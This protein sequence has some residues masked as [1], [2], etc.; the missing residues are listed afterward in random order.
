MSKRGF[1]IVL[2]GIDGS[3]STTQGRELAHHLR[4]KHGREVTLTHEPSG[5]PIGAIIRLA[6]QGRIV[7]TDLRNTFDESQAAGEEPR[8][9]DARTYALLFA[10]DRTDHLATEV[11]PSLARGRDVV[12]D[13]YLLSMLAYQGVSVDVEWLLEISRGALVP[14]LTIFL[15]LPVE[16]ALERMREARWTREQFETRENL[17]RVIERYER[18]L[19]MRLPQLGPV[20]RIDSS[21]PLPVVTRRVAT[22]VNRLLA[23]RG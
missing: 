7:G 14:D 8:G 15:D 4:A 19:A 21:L 2:E 18:V 5:G 16:T 13:R 1:F 23:S 9:L 20:V 6:L 12:C 11:E 10:A 3:G 22:E 17:E